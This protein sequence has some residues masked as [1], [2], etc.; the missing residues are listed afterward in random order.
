MTITMTRNEV[1]LETARRAMKKMLEDRDMFKMRL[2][3]H[4]ESEFDQLQTY[5]KYIYISI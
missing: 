2:S 1:S 5:F 3:M 4:I